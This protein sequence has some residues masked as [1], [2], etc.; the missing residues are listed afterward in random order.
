MALDD[1]LV[2]ASLTMSFFGQALSSLMLQQREKRSHNGIASMMKSLMKE[3]SGRQFGRLGNLPWEY[4]SLR[5]T[6]IN[7]NCL[8]SCKIDAESQGPQHFTCSGHI[9]KILHGGWIEKFTLGSF[10]EIH[11][12]SG[13]IWLPPNNL[14]NKM[15]QVLLVLGQA[16]LVLL[17]MMPLS[18]MSQMSL[19]GRPWHCCRTIWY[20]SGWGRTTNKSKTAESQKNTKLLG[21]C[22]DDFWHERNAHK[23][24]KQKQFNYCN[25]DCV[26]FERNENKK[27]ENCFTYIQTV[28][29]CNQYNSFLVQKNSRS[30][31][32]SISENGYCACVQLQV[33][34]S[35]VIRSMQIT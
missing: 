3:L 13:K 35:D 28:V 27:Y 14:A 5:Q 7:A 18:Q 10:Q 17:A 15:K 24:M 32:Y 12:R 34:G 11:Y 22:T 6:P 29:R 1:G 25:N 4:S 8:C 33:Q 21:A 31:K 19:I 20:N 30:V 2:S 16:P 9:Q 23:T 26:K